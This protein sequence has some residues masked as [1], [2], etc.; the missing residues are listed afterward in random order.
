[1]EDPRAPWH[2]SVSGDNIRVILCDEVPAAHGVGG[3]AEISPLVATTELGSEGR[4]LGSRSMT[5][6]LRN[7]GGGLANVVGTIVPL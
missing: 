3:M 4:W 6:P 5:W 7:D 2:D 1:M